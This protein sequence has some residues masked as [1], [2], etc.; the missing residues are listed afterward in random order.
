MCAHERTH[1]QSD[2][3]S[4]SLSL[5]PAFAVHPHVAFNSVNYRSKTQRD[6]DFV[7]VQFR[8]DV[9]SE[10]IRLVRRFAFLCMLI[11]LHSK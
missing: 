4:H 6:E 2:S 5:A 11:R 1:D 10:W 7:T 3:Q 9:S 8:A